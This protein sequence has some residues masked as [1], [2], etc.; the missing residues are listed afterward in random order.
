MNEK[1]ELRKN[2][3]STLKDLDIRNETG[4][5]ILDIEKTEIEKRKKDLLDEVEE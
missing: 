5:S 2:L 3:R 1:E 4:S